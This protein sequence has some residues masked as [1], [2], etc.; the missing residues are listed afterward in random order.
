MSS[1]WKERNT[2]TRKDRKYGKENPCQSEEGAK[3][4]TNHQPPQ[5]GGAVPNPIWVGSK[6]LLAFLGSQLPWALPFIFSLC[7]PLN[8]R[9]RAPHSFF[10]I[11]FLFSLFFFSHPSLALLH[12]LIFLFLLMSGNVHPNPDP[13]F[14]CSVC[15]ENVTWWG[16]SVQCCTF[17]KSVH[18]RCS[19]LSLSKFRTLG[20]S[21]SW[22]CPPCHN[23]VTPSLDSSDM[24]ASTI[25][26]G[27]PSANAA[28]SPHPRLQTSSYLPSSHFI[29][30]PSAPHHRPLLLAVLLRFLSSS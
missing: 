28:L 4:C 18:L 10:K 12:L 29:S 7:R 11:G 19:Q 2:A 5:C 17:S 27:L 24:Y 30:S 20:S 26:S 1:R 8:N 3:D 22:S 6:W 13:I 15:A 14:P 21:H 25:Q 9:S 23:T 16:K